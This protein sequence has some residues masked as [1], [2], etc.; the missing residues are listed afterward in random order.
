[1]AVLCNDL[2]ATESFSD[3]ASIVER[4]IRSV[5]AV[6]LEV[7]DRVLG[8]IYLDASDPEARFDEIIC[9]C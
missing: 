5:L 9:S 4:R 2:P 7:F 6:P 3:T 1:V 8:V